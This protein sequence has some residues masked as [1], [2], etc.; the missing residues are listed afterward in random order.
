LKEI[1]EREEEA[2]TLKDHVLVLEKE[3]EKQKEMR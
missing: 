1:K 2:S 3:V